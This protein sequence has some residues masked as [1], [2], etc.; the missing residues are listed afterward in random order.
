[1]A[2]HFNES[3]ADEWAEKGKIRLGGAYFEAIRA[4]EAEVLPRLD[5]LVF[6]SRFMRDRLFERIPALR[7]TP[8]TV[9]PNFCSDVVTSPMRSPPPADLITIGTLEPRKN[10]GFLLRVLAQA[11]SL[12]YQ[13]SL[14]I[15][16]DGPD[17][18][19]LQ[20][21]AREL[22]VEEQI[23]FHGYPPNAAQHLPGHRAYVHAATIEN[24]P[25]TLIE[26]LSCGLPVFAPAVGG[27]PELIDDQIQGFHWPL[28]S[29]RVAAQQLIDCLEN[30]PRHTRMAAAALERYKA[31]LSAERL[32]GRL[33]GFLLDRSRLQDIFPADAARA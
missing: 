9:V 25:I 7:A 1:M 24:C 23:R 3:Q 20:R 15:L 12:G 2:V 28:D 10:Q 29:P 26:A 5:G 13:Y 8:H 33:A 30:E 14:D 11:A 17:R 21:L 31:E 6:V 32:A 18:D 22:G 16:G 19:R 4:M 27:I